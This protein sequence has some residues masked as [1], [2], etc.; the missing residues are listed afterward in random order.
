[1]VN[2]G[3]G[4]RHRLWLGRWGVC[5]TRCNE[6][7]PWYLTTWGRDG[8]LNFKGICGVL[9]ISWRE[10]FSCCEVSYQLQRTFDHGLS[11]PIQRS[12]T[13]AADD[14]LR[15]RALLGW[16]IASPTYLC[17]I[18]AG[19]QERC[20]RRCIASLEPCHMLSRR[21]QRTSP[22]SRVT[23]PTCH[24]ALFSEPRPN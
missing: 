1:M 11:R 20:M 24:S 17:K 13:T 3:E 8:I 19:S 4:S 15:Q 18:T 6:L 10:V 23:L 21:L 22:A 16:M 7:E 14:G 5:R 12:R 2:L 9:Y